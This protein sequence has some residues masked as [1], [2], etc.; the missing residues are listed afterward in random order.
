[1]TDAPRRP[2]IYYPDPPAD[3]APPDAE[4]RL[5]DA[6]RGLNELR[7]TVDPWAAGAG[8]LDAVTT[9]VGEARC[10][11]LLLADAEAIFVAPRELAPGFGE[12]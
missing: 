2:G 3:P 11:D 9:L 8:E 4:H 10:G 5:A 1:M 6:R 7:T 12:A